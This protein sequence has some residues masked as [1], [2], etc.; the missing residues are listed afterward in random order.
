MAYTVDFSDGTK[1]PLS[2]AN[3]GVNTN[4]N[5]GLVGQGFRNYGE[6]IAENLLRLLENFA[7]GSAPSKPVEGQLWY[8]SVNNQLKYFDDTISNSG[9]WK[10][11]ASMTVQSNPPTSVGERDGHFWLDTDT[12]I[13]SLYYNGSWISINDVAGDTRVVARTRY[14]ISD[15]THRTIEVIVDGKIVSITSSD[16]MAW[17]PQNSGPN[18]EYLEDGITLLNTQ[19][20]TVSNPIKQGVNLNLTEDY[21]FNGTATSALYADLAERY[22]ADAVYEYGTVVKIGGTKEITATDKEYC[23][24]VFGVIS[25]KPAFAMNSGAGDSS[26]H[27]YVALSGRVPVRVVGKVNKGDR[28]V[29]SNVLGHAMAG[30]DGLNWQYVIGRALE[31]KVNDESGVIE[32]VVGTK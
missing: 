6:V 20:G 28:L 32:A 23:A 25:D 15:A 21:V 27:P 30:G 13:L 19:F 9:N 14:D 1:T 24:D 3:S 12:G 10:P 31:D 29:S 11:I 26:T 7:S 18:T 5:L 22:A 17:R 16:A 4:T 8:D 2:V